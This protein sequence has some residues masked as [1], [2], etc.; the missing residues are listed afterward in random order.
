M[1][2]NYDS[3]IYCIIIF[4]IHHFSVHLAE[5]IFWLNVVELI[6]THYYYLMYLLY[7]HMKFSF[8]QKAINRFQLSFSF[9]K[10]FFGIEKTIDQ[11]MMTPSRDGITDI[12]NLKHHRVQ[13]R[14][15]NK[16]INWLLEFGAILN[17][18]QPYSVFISLR[19]YV[20]YMNGWAM[21]DL[22]TK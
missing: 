22:S 12:Q 15:K 5:I 4:F 1:N 18:Q 14:C 2:I 21:D 19:T 11:V 10:H 13:E 8:R 17:R 20:Y 7:V 16:S 3:S 6:V 9:I